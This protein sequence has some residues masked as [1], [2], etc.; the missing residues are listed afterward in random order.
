VSGKMTTTT[1]NDDDTF[2]METASKVILRELGQENR[3]RVLSGLYIARSDV[4]LNVR[5]AA[6]HVWK[7]VV[8][9][10]P[11]TLKEIMK[12]L[13]EL[14]L[15]C[16]ASS[17]EEKQQIAARC[18]GELV[19]KMGERI[20]I[21][22]VPVLEEGLKSDHADQRQ[23]VCIAL[24]EIIA[25]TTKDVVLMYSANL[26]PTVRT[27]LFDPLPEVRSA[28]ACTF[29]VLHQSI[30]NA[31]LEDILTPLLEQLVRAFLIRQSCE[32]PSALL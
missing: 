11:R 21:E 18:L 1:Q 32:M 13:F 26:V 6:G 16:L 2:G 29:D 12:T 4:A 31:A 3:D 5:Q 25:N 15:G 19:K 24:Q 8:A 10:T 22:V 28:A 7:I 23:G 20:L 30:G 9:N 14:L 27:A 17:S